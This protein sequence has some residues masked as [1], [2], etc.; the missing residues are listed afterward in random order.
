LTTHCRQPI[1]HLFNELF[2]AEKASIMTRQV[3]R[4]IGG[5][6]PMILLASG[7]L[8]QGTPP[9]PPQP[10][11]LPPDQANRLTL[12]L[13][14]IRRA[15]SNTREQERREQ[16][17]RLYEEAQRRKAALEKGKATESK[18]TDSITKF[19]LKEFAD[20]NQKEIGALATT[21]EEKKANRIELMMRRSYSPESYSSGSAEKHTKPVDRAPTVI[22]SSPTPSSDAAP[23]TTLRDYTS[24]TTRRLQESGVTNSVVRPLSPTL[25]VSNRSFSIFNRAPKTEEAAPR[26]TPSSGTAFRPA[27]ST[28]GGSGATQGAIG[29]ASQ[30]PPASV[31]DVVRPSTA[32]AGPLEVVNSSLKDGRYDNPV[33]PYDP[34]GMTTTAEGRLK[35]AQSAKPGEKLNPDASRSVSPYASYLQTPSPFDSLAL[36]PNQQK[37]SGTQSALGGND[38]ALTGY[39]PNLL[40]NLQ[41]S[42]PGAAV[43]GATPNQDS[44][45][46]L[47]APAFV[48]S[49]V[50]PS[51][52]GGSLTPSAASAPLT[53]GGLSFPTVGAYGSHPIGSFQPIGPAQTTPRRGGLSP[54]GYYETKSITDL[55][56]GR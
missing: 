11:T 19:N 18:P 42:V 48:G 27:L 41:P 15:S 4:V 5:V 20:E 2:E 32:V 50:L 40:G 49:P 25:S 36:N 47:L 3:S 33:R 16:M 13:D 38:Q 6:L 26:S 35:D 14:E 46:S 9:P 39:Q 23:D 1:L 55:Q 17:L 54:S 43:A 22:R 10:T 34:V 51:S 12:S 37:Q 56:Y 24:T 7:V 44:K 52:P 31:L 53:P 29:S 30:T 28:G 8:A 21:Y 45:G